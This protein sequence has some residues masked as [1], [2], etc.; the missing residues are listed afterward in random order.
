MVLT[1]DGRVCDGGRTESALGRYDD[2]QLTNPMLRR[3]GERVEVLLDDTPRNR[4][5]LGHP[6]EG[7]EV[8]RFNGERHTATV[9]VEGVP[10]IK[11]YARLLEFSDRTGFRIEVH[12]PG[13]SWAESAALGMLHAAGIGWQGQFDFEQIARTWEEG[14]AVCFLPLFREGF[15][16]LHPSGYKEVE[17]ILP[18]NDYHPF[19][20]LYDLVQAIFGRAGYTLTSEFF[21]S[22][23]FRSLYMSGAYASTDT[24]AMYRRYGF[25]A[26]RKG[27]VSAT[28]N[29]S[30]RVYTSLPV[31]ASS[32]GPVVNA[33]TPTET[34]ASGQPMGDICNNGGVLV[35]EDGEPVFKPRNRVKASFR[36]HLEYTTDYRILS[37]T[38]LQGFDSFYLG[39]GVTL[40]GQLTNLFADKRGEPLAA[41]S[42]TAVVFEASAGNTYRVVDG[43]GAVMASFQ[44]RTGSVVTAAT[45]TPSQPSLQVQTAD[46]WI[47]SALDWALYNGS[48]GER[49]TMRVE[50]DVDT[51]VVEVPTSGRHFHSVYFAGAEPGMKL[52]LHEGTTLGVDFSQKPGFGSL[53]RFGDVARHPVRQSVL[54]EALIHL[55]N[56]RV[57]T[58]TEALEIRVEPEAQFYDRSRVVDWSDRVDRSQPVV[59][60]DRAL[61]ERESRLYHY[62][63]S[64]AGD[65]AADGGDGNGENGGS[66]GNSG[67]AAAGNGT[68][69]AAWRVSTQ[70]FATR[71]GCEQRVNPLFGAVKERDGFRVNA[72]SAEVVAPEGTNAEGYFTPCIVSFHGLRPLPEGEVWGWPAPDGYYPAARFSQTADGTSLRFDGTD[73][74]AGLRRFHDHEEER[75]S[76]A[77]Q[78]TLTLRLWP[79]EVALLRHCARGD[80]AGC[81]SLFRLTAEPDG[82][83]YLLRRLERYDPETHT[84]RC[85]FENAL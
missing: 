15:E 47:P 77:R 17:R 43:Q 36:F 27:E 5:I 73:T 6:D 44:G 46:G 39:D 34:D 22:E 10:L 29:A 21:E 45:W 23:F 8:E 64:A 59:Y 33:F 58:D 70:N 18:A 65:D 35:I 52:T 38:R 68:P 41:H 62:A 19:L 49:G 11:G 76:F 25:F 9:E 2:A 13:A 66:S 56:L 83:P 40:R 31:H 84:A 81:N 60:R 57:Y 24:S 37:R 82:E 51:P 61:D 20:R 55:F 1:I 78:V 12:A 75:R 48:V 53:V 79:E 4:E 50:I 3:E 14:A 71:E 32:L 42:Y 85:L 16:P 69:Y 30:G 28:A 67:D 54:V 63:G 74:A 26:R 72:P 80:I 7:P